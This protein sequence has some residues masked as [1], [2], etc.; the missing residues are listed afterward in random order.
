MNGT[1]EPF[2][3]VLL[4]G[5]EGN[6]GHTAEMESLAIRTIE[7]AL[8]L[9]STYD[10]DR[11]EAMWNLCCVA[12]FRDAPDQQRAADYL[13]LARRLGNA[14]ALA[15]GLMQTG[16]AD[17]DRD[18]ATEL[19]AEA[20]D[21]TARTRDTYRY[22]LATDWLA[23]INADR[24]PHG[25]M[26]TVPVLVKHALITGQRLII[27]QIGRDVIISAWALGRPDAVAIL[28][29]ASGVAGI[30]MSRVAAAIDG[31]R[32][33]LGDGRYDELLAEGK[34]FSTPE[35]QDYLL[36]LASQLD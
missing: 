36:E 26:R 15:G 5:V 8:A 28:D 29:G 20:R 14:R 1:L 35:L 12:L 16:A 25:A 13:A 10:Y 33:K 31:A 9:G 7:R 3:L 6:A 30:R 4:S 17:P 23:A 32:Q 18:R 27:K 11:A 22:A 21:L 2:S 19:L 24:D 34:T